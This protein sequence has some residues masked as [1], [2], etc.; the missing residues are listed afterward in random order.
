MFNLKSLFIPT[1]EKRQVD[2]V[3]LWEVRWHSRHGEFSSCTQ[4]ECEVFPVKADAEAF[5]KALS[6]AFALIKHTSGTRVSIEHK[7]AI[8]ARRAEGKSDG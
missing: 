4:P 3:E 6:D 5:A 8:P 7:V 1:A 2:A